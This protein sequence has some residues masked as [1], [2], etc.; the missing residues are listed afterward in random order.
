MLV[1]ANVKQVQK[2]TVILVRSVHLAICQHG[3]ETPMGQSFMKVYIPNFY[4]NL[5]AYH[6]VC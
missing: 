4:Q 2:V 6:D 3:T 1:D 5:S